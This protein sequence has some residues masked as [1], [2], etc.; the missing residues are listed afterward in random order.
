MK[1][2]SAMLPDGVL[3]RTLAVAFVVSLLGVTYLAIAPNQSEERLDELYILNSS[4][5][6]ANY[7]TSLT[8]G[9][10]GVVRLGVGNRR[11][12]PETY[13]VSGRFGNRSVAN[14]TLTVAGDETVERS[15]SFTPRTAGEFTLRFRLHR[16]GPDADDPLTVRLLV[17]VSPE[18]SGTTPQG[19]ESDPGAVLQEDQQL[20]VGGP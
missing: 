3:T 11:S 2:V 4:G 17:T 13:R 10:T 20:F 9:E 14:Y 1:Q 15:V 12:G 7:P 6:A 19:A 16:D 18:A 5:V 8:V